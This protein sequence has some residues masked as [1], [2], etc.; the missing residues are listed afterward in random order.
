[1]QQRVKAGNFTLI[2]I[3]H[4]TINCRFHVIFINFCNCSSGSDCKSL[5][6]HYD[7]FF[8]SMLCN[9]YFR[10]V[11]TQLEKIA[12]NAFCQITLDKEK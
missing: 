9:N 8:W 10:S 7:G 5:T 6:P 4:V 2:A 3:F 11:L 1:M 12:H